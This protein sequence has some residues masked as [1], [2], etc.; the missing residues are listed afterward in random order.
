MVLLVEAVAGLAG[1]SLDSQREVNL[2]FRHAGS[3]AF[4]S[5]LAKLVLSALGTTDLTLGFFL[6][7]YCNFLVDVCWLP[8]LIFFSR[9]GRNSRNC[10]VV[11]RELIQ[12]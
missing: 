7:F 5:E 4:E 9:F 1:K 3:A 10:S 11:L 2:V 12:V 6:I 8:L